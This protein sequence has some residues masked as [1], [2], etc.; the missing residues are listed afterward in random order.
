MQHDHLERGMHL[1]LCIPILGN[2][3]TGLELTIDILA[4]TASLLLANFMLI[5]FLTT[6][7]F[8]LP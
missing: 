8:K 2:N 3:F 5:F 7:I 6:N 4:A 1:E